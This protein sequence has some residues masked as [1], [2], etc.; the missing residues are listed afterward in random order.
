MN[1]LIDK[2]AREK[3]I[4]QLDW[5]FFVEAG[6][7][8]GKT[9]CLVERMVNL[10]KRGRA[11][12]ENIA[13]VTF[14]RKAAAELKER[15]QIRLE[16]S[17]CKSI[18][19]TADE[20]KNIQDALFNLEQIYIGTIH[21][22]CS[23]ILR[24]RPVE[25]GVDSE[26]EEIE[27]EKDFI[28]AQEAW[29]AFIDYSN[30]TGDNALK[31]ME[32]YGIEINDLEDTYHRFIQYSDV[33]IETS[34]T[35][36]PDFSEVKKAI[37]NFLILF[38]DM[39][40]QEA[41][42]KG[43][44]SLQ[45]IIRKSIFYFNSG[46]LN[47][48][49]L[50]VRVLNEMSKTPEIVQNRW[51]DGNGKDCKEKMLKFQNDILK[52]ALTSWRQYMH[53][54]LADFIKKGADFYRDWRENH[55]IL[56]FEDLLTMTSDLLRENSE[57]REYF[58]KKFTHILVDEFQDTDPIQAEIIFFL[59]GK[60]TTE[61]D[62]KNI[63]LDSGALFLVGDPKQ[64]IYRFRR[65]DIDIYNTVKKIFSGECCEE[66]RLFSNFRSLPFMHDLV[67]SV[68]KKILPADEDKYQAKYF[69]LNTTRKTEKGYDFG[70]FE[71]NTGKTHMGNAAEITAIDAA[72]VAE[73]VYYSVNAGAV[74]LQRTS[75]ELKSGLTGKPEYSDF[76][77]LTKKRQSLGLYAKALEKNGIPYNISGGL[78]FNESLELSEI[79]KLFKAID[80]D[81]DPVALVSVLRG[82]FFGISDESL[83]NF[84]KAG[85]NFSYFSLAPAGFSNFEEAFKRL[86][87]YGKIINTNKPVVAAE[88]IIEKSGIIPRALS[89]EEGLTR[90]GNIY[91]A[92]ELLKDFGADKIETFYDLTK[93]MEEIL[94]NKE[95]ESMSLLVSKKN[96]VRLMN[97][98]KAKGLEAP[99]VILADPMGEAKHFEPQYHIS[100]T[101]GKKA[102]G[103]FSIIKPTSNYSS[104]ILGI[105]PDWDNKLSEEKKY[106]EAER[107]RLEYVAVTRAKNI[108][109]VSTYRE[110]TKAKAWEILYDFLENAKKIELPKNMDIME[111]E[112]VDISK[113]EWEKE[114]DR[115]R[116]SL[117]F[118]SSAS[119]SINKV[120]SEAK[121][122][123]IFTGRAGGKGA[124]WGSISHKVIEL[125]C[126]GY[127]ER[128]QLLTKKWIDEAGIEERSADELAALVDR[129]M[130]SSLWERVMTANEKLFETPFAYKSNGGIL[131]GVID[132]IFKENNK[133][134]IVDYKTD[135][136]E[137]DKERK[138]VYLK[139]LELYKKYWESITREEVSEIILYKL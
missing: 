3:I 132:L 52:P 119:Y 94:K 62:W 21:S 61:T 93:N 98:H 38:K 104:E 11:K 18:D 91:K 35:S 42:E 123:F 114:K 17:L 77:I 6:A 135:D 133:W 95:I 45:S 37:N 139:Q 40:S 36:E 130:K 31:F 55:S 23:K 64:S 118:I 96:A 126:N 112:T 107:R 85:G 43:W 27:E 63:I 20:K 59:T 5:N 14:T 8:S 12:I 24:E 51:P 82:L 49:R 124:K 116:D 48:N 87:E 56:N 58:K 122:D 2:K 29:S 115:I 101:R 70:V 47:S 89:E 90:A 19:L 68:F 81:K 131:Y 44:D 137:T 113:P 66:L 32:E 84:K 88:I 99:V 111:V 28:Y 105:P 78:V 100:R 128:I 50:F 103:Y 46:Y 108:L 71:N 53:K 92:M 109:A 73:W 106:G 33:E 54:P 83:Y 74:K 129:F 7:G 127:Y 9:Y 79:L 134:V 120:T 39:M 4:N 125:A 15:F 102:K 13:A 65:A 97:L 10:I 69:P 22:F 41:P 34:D 60:N 1:E 72:K 57:V 67:E 76:L 75:D 30:E 80:D 136:F 117:S 16:D 25:A 110:G 86:K 26:F 121:E 138:T